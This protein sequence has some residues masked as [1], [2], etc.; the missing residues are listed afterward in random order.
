MIRHILLIDDDSLVLKSLK[1]LLCRENYAVTLAGSFEEAMTAI[2]QTDFA[3]VISDI[4]MPGKDGVETTRTIQDVLIKAG[5]KDLPIIFM[6]GF[7]GED[8][9]LNASSIG[10]TLYKP[11]DAQK[12][13][14][15]IRDYL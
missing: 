3:L 12:L 7:S 8:L 1:K 10:E 2:L 5:K 11:I 9:R 6:T 13:L 4:R 15:A 14:L